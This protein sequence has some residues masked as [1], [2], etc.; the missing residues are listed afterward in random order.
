MKFKYLILILISAFGANAQTNIN[1][2]I[3]EDITW[4]NS[5]SPY[6]IDG[7]LLINSEV[8]LTI[9]AG[10]TIKFD[11]ETTLQ[12]NGELIAVGSQSE[13]IVFTSNS[14]IPQP[15]DWNN[16]HFTASSTMANYDAGGNYLSGSI[17]QHCKFNYGGRLNK[18]IL[19]IDGTTPHI[20]QCTINQSSSNGIY[21]QKADL[22]IDQCDISNNGGAGFFSPTNYYRGSLEIKDSNL[23]NNLMGG[24]RVENTGNKDI[25]IRNNTISNNAKNAI[26]LDSPGGSGSGTVII[27]ENKI[28]KNNGAL[29]IDGGFDINIECNLFEQNYGNSPLIYMNNGWNPYTISISKNTIKNNITTSNKL[30]NIYY[31]ISYPT[32]F[33]I[34][35]NELIE[36]EV[37]F[38]GAII[39]IR[40]GKQ[41]G[42]TFNLQNNTLL[43]NMGTSTLD[44]EEFDGRIS[45]NTIS[46]N[47]NYEIYNRNEA[48]AL[49]ITATNNYW[50][51]DGEI[52]TKI[53]D[54]FDDPTRS[55]AMI[56]P[57]LTSPIIT[58]NACSYLV[59][60]DNDF[61]GI[62]DDVD[63]CPFIWNPNQNDE[64]D[65]GIGDLCDDFDED[66]IVDIYDNCPYTANADQKDI[67]ANGIGD[68]CD[69]YDGDGVLDNEDNCWYTSNPNQEDFNEN[70][71]G[72]VC[73]DSDGDGVYDDVDNCIYHWNPNQADIN[74]NGIGD[75]CEDTDGDGVRDSEDNC[76][77]VSNSHQL[78]T[79]NDGVGDVCDDSDGDGVYDDVDNCI[80]HWNPD[81]VDTN[82]NG[83]GDFCD[84]SDNDGVYDYIDNC[85]LTPPG[86][87]VN[88]NG[89]HLL[90]LPSDN[91][92]II[93][94]SANCI[95]SATGSIAI[96]VMDASYK[97][98][99][100]IVG[101]DGF[102]DSFLIEQLQTESIINSLNSGVYQICFT[103]EENSIF[104]QCFELMVNE[105]EPLMALEILNISDR[106]LDLKL[107]GASQYNVVVN[108]KYRKTKGSELSIALKSGLNQ[109]DVTT[110]LD[111]QG[112]FS[113]TIFISEE[114]R[115]FPNPTLGPIQIYIDRPDNEVNIKIYD[116]NNSLI[117]HKIQRISDH[118]LNMDV[119]NLS[120]GIYFIEVS[121]EKIYHSFKLIKK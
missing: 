36:N 59:L 102:N 9:E 74:N 121:G 63:N 75:A 115:I 46:N 112:K 21:V 58:N 28:Y 13:P 98:L 17:I 16:I 105:P 12:I 37:K 101:N 72:D 45:N 96:E 11:K 94:T 19:F 90:E 52:E 111:C 70:G 84:D 108:G 41:F 14:T 31:R 73:D 44:L 113:K 5:N 107:S 81:Q 30:L 48:G 60:K 10:V 104:E 83:I 22:K 57:E 40:G 50:N 38:G 20:Q 86:L 120:S 97:Y 47:T 78:D 42:D 80:Y 34:S 43:N 55:L 114:A 66:G 110:D 29:S 23:S 6:I 88:E 7:N 109:I 77:F 99:V 8:T 100:N 3:A 89:C 32:D 53:Y 33:L 1:G 64:N 27:S 71:I 15:G 82:E 4:T 79:D 106:L 118:F 35:D 62:Y 18:G 49:D 93:V 51:M 54:W 26:F 56:S 39:Y 25:L 117:N 61:D 76:P 65:N 67:N 92:K 24:F 91:F 85:P 119:S 2:I 87:T 95:G 116:F 69:D 68:V 103:I